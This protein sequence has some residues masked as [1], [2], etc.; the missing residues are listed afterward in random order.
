VVHSNHHSNSWKGKANYYSL[1]VD[2]DLKPEAVWYYPEP[3]EAAAQLKG[4]VA[5]AQGV[6]IEP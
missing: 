2:G 6:K 4:R 5:F 1:L 3:T